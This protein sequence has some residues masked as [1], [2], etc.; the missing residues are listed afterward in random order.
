MKIPIGPV[1]P[2]LEEPLGL[3]F[4]VEGEDIVDVDFRCGYNHRGIEKLMETKDFNQNS[5]L[6]E[7]I[8]G[9]CSYT[10]SLCYHNAVESVGE[11]VEVSKRAHYLR[12]ITAELERV[13]SHLLWAGIAGEEIG[14]KSLFMYA[15]KHRE[16]CMDSLE[17]IT[18]NRV[19]YG[20]NRVGGVRYDLT[21]EMGKRLIERMDK[22]DEAV[23][24]MANIFLKDPM[25]D[26]RASNIGI[27][28]KK[29]AYDL[30]A[31]GP[32]ARASGV[33]ADIRK[34][35]PYS[36]YNEFD[37][38]V[39]TWDSGDILARAAVRIL[40]LKES[41]KIIRQAVKN[42]P[43]GALWNKNWKIPA[44]ESVSRTEAP[45]G[46]DIHY[47]RTDGGNKPYRYKIRAPTLA[48]I[49]S[50]PAMFKKEHIADI[51]I[52]VASIDP[53]IGC[54][55]RVTLVDATSGKRRIVMMKELRK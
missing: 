32:T 2:A 41:A 8:C 14:N 22:T 28:T 11:G 18:G 50:V 21:P 40:E 27:L 53:C 33:K 6:I 13:H 5:F 7:R 46:E 45:R 43:E 24:Y 15:W 19:N 12:V 42:L 52:I 10:H 31:V 48:N 20:I 37:F 9:I 17:E 16:L 29:E 3:S 4:T 35:D 44:G 34:D 39:I 47:V 49:L 54:M 25:I 26:K 23:D 38:N 55:D 1:H 51:P 30:G 36:C